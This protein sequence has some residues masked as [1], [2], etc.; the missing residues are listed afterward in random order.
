MTK[1]ALLKLLL[2]QTDSF[3]SGAELARQLS[4]SRTAVWKG[5]EALREDGY[6][7]DSVTNRG[8]RL[9]AESDVLS[10][11]GIGRYLNAEAFR[12]Q[13]YPSVS[14]TNT[15]LKQ[16]A[17]EGAPEGTVIVAGEQTAGRGRMGRSFFSPSGSGLY[18]SMLLR[19]Q[20]TPAETTR[21]TAYAAVVVAEAI[22]S[23]SGAETRIKWVNDIYV[24]GKKVS[25]ILTEAALDCERGITD[26]VIVGIGINIRVPEGDFPAELREIAGAVFGTDAA[27]ALRCRLAAEVIARFFAFYRSD[28]PDTAQTCYDAYKRRSLVLNRRV[29]LHSVAQPPVEA[30]AIDI[31]PDFALVVRFPDGTVRHVNSGEV[32]IRLQEGCGDIRDR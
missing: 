29:L 31:A 15:L 7:I 3:I 21:L 12:L 32:S 6:R 23:L 26:Y 16:Q 13:V 9:S 8:Y 25:G 14:S 1:D 19:P 17:G 2:E 11:E 18:L 24:G 4:V 20:S 22:E 27:P 10:A 28:R 5:I 30:E